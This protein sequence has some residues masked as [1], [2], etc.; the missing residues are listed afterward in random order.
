MTKKVVTALSA[1]TMLLTAAGCS[2]QAYDKDAEPA[3]REIVGGWTEEDGAITDEMK[4][5]FDKAFGQL[6]GVSYKPIR[7]I[8][9][10]LV[11]GKNY[12][13]LCEATLPGQNS[14]P[15]MKVVTI[16]VDLQGNTSILSIEDPEE[17]TAGTQI[18]NPFE[19]ADTIEEAEEHVE[20][21]FDIPFS[22]EDLDIEDISF[23]SEYMIQVTYGEDNDIMIRK[24]KDT[25]DISG[26]YNVYEKNE[27]FMV[28]DV[29][30]Y[31]HSNADGIHVITW[32]NNDFSYA[33]TS[34]KGITGELADLI[35]EFM[36]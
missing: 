31:V 34:K 36:Q 17:E 6:I 10:Q 12:K 1:L 7:L 9:T 15:V 26:D 24:A 5:L 27:S 11:S 2:V 4:E 3:E 16:Y 29:T 35:H 13:F 22:F 25:E 20:F 19:E 23:I 18:A 8:S 28:D 30:V 14:D 33:I 21:E 32:T